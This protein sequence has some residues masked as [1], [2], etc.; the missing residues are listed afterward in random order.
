MAPDDPIVAEVRETRKKIE[1]AANNDFETLYERMVELQKQYPYRLITAP[2]PLPVVT[3][4]TERRRD[5]D[6]SDNI[7]LD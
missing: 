4:Y 1:M 6:E 5:P 3:L 2:L 7:R